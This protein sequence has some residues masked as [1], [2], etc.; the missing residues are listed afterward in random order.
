[1]GNFHRWLCGLAPCA[2]DAECTSVAEMLCKILLPRMPIFLKEGTS[3][4]Q[5]YVDFANLLADFVCSSDPGHIVSV[6]HHEASLIEALQQCIS[7]THTTGE[8]AAPFDP[9]ASFDTAQAGSESLA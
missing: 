4:H 2:L 1:M 5:A 7:A 3:Q 8:L 6:L 9:P